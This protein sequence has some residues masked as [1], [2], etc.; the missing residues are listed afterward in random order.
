[1]SKKKVARVESARS[2]VKRTQSNT[3]YALFIARQTGA[4]SE[5]LEVLAASIIARAA[6][7]THWDAISE[8]MKQW[9]GCV[10]SGCVGPVSGYP[11]GHPEI[12]A[13][14]DR[15]IDEIRAVDG[16][17]DLTPEQL[18]AEH[19]RRFELLNDSSGSP[20]SFEIWGTIV[21]VMR[22]SGVMPAREEAAHA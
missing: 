5:A 9:F 17:R 14:D 3:G 15:F 19:E 12:D 7:A 11:A 20:E 10:A 6:G 16:G 13:L 2:K 22:M 21:R 8:P 1:M 18:R 4:G